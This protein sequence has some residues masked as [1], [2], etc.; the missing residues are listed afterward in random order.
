MS[1]GMSQGNTLLAV[2]CRMARAALQIGVRDLAEAAN[3]SPT[4]ITKLERG[5]TLYPRTVESIRTALE[6]AGVIFI[7][8]NGDGPG[9]RLRKDGEVS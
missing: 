8:Q 3:V 6:A 1:T 7:Q 9:V 4:T 5:E 2:Q